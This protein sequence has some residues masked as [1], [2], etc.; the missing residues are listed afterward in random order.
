MNRVC[1]VFSECSGA[2]RVR[3]LS[4]FGWT[5]RSVCSV[6]F[7]ENLCKSL[8]ES[9]WEICEKVGRFLWISEFCTKI[10]LI[11][12]TFRMWVEKFYRGFSTGFISVK[13]PFCTVSTGFTI[14]T[15][16]ILGGH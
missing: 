4:L 6:D 5:V 2:S 16:N 3:F 11:L 7:V 1:S 8:C 13:R 12:H 14:T 9:L 15:I 10:G